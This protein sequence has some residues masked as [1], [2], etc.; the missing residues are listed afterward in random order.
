MGLI[1]GLCESVKYIH[2]PNLGTQC[3]CRPQGAQKGHS[4]AGIALVVP[5]KLNLTASA[6]K[7]IQDNGVCYLWQQVCILQSIFLTMLCTIT[8]SC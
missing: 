5:V 4:N 7:Y 1:S 3:L 6:Y 2:I 8:L